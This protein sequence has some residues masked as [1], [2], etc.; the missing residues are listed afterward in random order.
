MDT[1]MSQCSARGD[2]W[3]DRVRARLLAVH[4][5]PAADAT[6]H[7]Q[8]SINFRTGRPLPRVF[9]WD[10]D[11][12]VQK[13]QKFGRPSKTNLSGRHV[14]DEQSAAFLKI[15][16]FLLENDDEQT[17]VSD[18]VEKMAEYLSETDIEPFS[19]KYMK[20]KL[21]E[22]FKGQ[23]I[24]TR[25][26]RKCNVVTMRH[27]AASILQ[28]FHDAQSDDPE[29]EKSRIIEAAA[30]FIRDDIRAVRT[31]TYFYPASSD[32]ESEEACLSYL[33]T[34]L[35]LFLGTVMHGKDTGVKVASIGQAI[36]QAARPR[37]LLAPLQVSLA[38]QLHHHFAS[39]FLVD[40]LHSLGFCASYQEVKR[41]E[42]NAAVDQGVN[43]PNHTSQF[44]Q[45]AADN[46]DHNIVTLD[47]NDTFHGM[48]IIAMVTPGTTQSHPVKR[49]TVL[50][51]DV[52]TRGHIRIQYHRM[53]N[54][55]IADLRY[56]RVSIHAAQDPTSDID[57]LWHASLLFGASRPTWYGM[58]QAVHLSEH[59]PKSS[60]IFLP[61]ID[62][63]STDPTCIFSTLS[64][65]AQHA[66]RHDVT[67]VITFDQPLWWKSLAMQLSQ[68]E[69]SP[70]QRIVLRLGAFHMEMSFLGS[71]GHLMAGS[72]LKELLEMIY[73][74]NSVVH[75]M[76]GKAISRAVRA[77]L[78]M[79]GVLNALL[80]SKSLDTPISN[81]SRAEPQHTDTA[82]SESPDNVTGDNEKH[83]DVLAAAL[84][85][86]ELMTKT[87]DVEE[88]SNDGVIARIKAIRDA[89][90][91]TLRNDLTA[92]LWIQYIDMVRILRMFIKAERLGNWYLHLQAVSEMLP[93]LAASGH[94]LYAKAARIYL[95]SMLCLHRDHPVVHQH[96]VEG[97][98]STQSFSSNASSSR[99]TLLTTRRR[100]S[101]SSYAAI[102]RLSLTILL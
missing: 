100:Y 65:V 71:I 13:K 62:M 66:D 24:I 83:T 8:C 52:S 38:V 84:L 50:P 91:D 98:L 54:Q 19:H 59:P 96:F 2:E 69:G 92:R 73:A 1:L 14:N 53:D 94:S 51:E 21:L 44:I 95:N 58:M 75:I 42:G 81:P 25:I 88:V 87:K 77:H 74:Q 47:G 37:V 12:V 93:Y 26:N 82:A 85:Y 102:H 31:S 79:D 101:G 35:Q 89:H 49:G 70:I 46:V 57:V 64:Y 4:D 15:A 23:V 3:A 80:L 9:K 34:T 63:S 90:V 32:I 6:Y 27:T 61:M 7:Q 60:V 55:A 97:L 29:K 17:T 72:G 76:T 36:M 28:E 99:P 10:D 22:Y 5:L 16:Q 45:Y 40:T 68:P 41:F 78:L 11:G 33:P 48:G 67:P 43:I 18:L 20:T 56:D 30:K 86:N 39:R